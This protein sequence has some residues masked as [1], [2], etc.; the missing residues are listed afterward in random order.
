MCYTSLTEH[1]NPEKKISMKTKDEKQIK[2][3]FVGYK[4][5]KQIVS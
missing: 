4:L 2:A 5:E 3:L 1:L